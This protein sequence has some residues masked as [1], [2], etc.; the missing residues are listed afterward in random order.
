MPCPGPFQFSYSVDYIYDFFVLSLTQMLA[1]LSVYVM[2]STQVSFHFSL[3]GHKFV[4]CLF[5]DCSILFHF[6]VK[7]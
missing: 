6:D 7:F 1:F 4:R 2:L 5:G 3:C